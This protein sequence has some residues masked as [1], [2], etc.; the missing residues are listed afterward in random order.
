MRSVLVTNLFFI[1]FIDP[2]VFQSWTLSTKKQPGTIQRANI[3]SVDKDKI[4]LEFENDGMLFRPCGSR[5]ADRK[6][7]ERDTCYAQH[8]ITICGYLSVTLFTMCHLV[9]T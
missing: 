9:K 1:L 4:D 5:T 3:Y 8:T 7:G 6:G 2:Y